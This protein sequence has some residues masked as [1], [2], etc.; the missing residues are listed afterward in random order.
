MGILDSIKKAF[1][2]AG[3]AEPTAGTGSALPDS[4]YIDTIEMERQQK[5]QFFRTNPYSPIEDKSSF[6]GLDYYPVEMSLRFALPLNR[7]DEPEPVTIQ[8]NTGEAR[9]FL[10]IGTVEF[11]VDGEAASLA[12]YRGVEHDEL[13]VPFRDATSGTETYGAGR[14]LEPQ[15]TRNGEIVL[16]FNAAYNPYCA[17]S[18]H[19]SCPLPPFENHLKVAIRAGEK[20]FK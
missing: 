15:E 5:D 9:P 7:A 13:F 10:R 14:Y 19:F 17:Y 3:A 6:A 4:F 20:K 8:T 2:G 16:D 11:E 18:A 12:V 1:G